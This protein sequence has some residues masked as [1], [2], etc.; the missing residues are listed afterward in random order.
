M[1]LQWISALLL[2]GALCAQAQ[3]APVTVEGAWVRPS[4]QGQTASG[5]YMTIIAREPVTLTGASSPVA[6]LTEVH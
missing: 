1:K 4:V 5:A 2:A 3:T 6:G